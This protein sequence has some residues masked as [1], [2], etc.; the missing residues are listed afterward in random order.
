MESYLI[1]G[2]SDTKKDF[3]VTVKVNDGLYLPTISENHLRIHQEIAFKLCDEIATQ[4]H[5]TKYYYLLKAP[6]DKIVHLRIWSLT[7]SAG[8]TY[9]TMHEGA[10]VTADGDEITSYN[11][12]RYSSN[13]AKMKV[14]KNSTI[15][16][17]GVALPECSK[18]EGDKRT[19]GSEGNKTL[20][21]DFT[22]GVNYLFEVENQSTT[23]LTRSIF[24]IFWYETELTNPIYG[25]PI[26]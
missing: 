4:L 13:P 23:T 12:K 14:Y 25:A 2:E 26:I 8:P 20:E 1:K 15:T 10:T 22:P 6:V 24:F 17:V 19:G 18:I 9:F 3:F 5:N 7:A 21:W 11:M 16:D